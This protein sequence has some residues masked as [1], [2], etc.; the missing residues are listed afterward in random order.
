MTLTFVIAITLI[1]VLKIE[2]QKEESEFTKSSFYRPNLVLKNN[3]FFLLFFFCFG[4]MIIVNILSKTRV[5]SFRNFGVLLSRV[6]KEC[7]IK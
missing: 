7:I 2:S 6:L 3:V 4:N 1:S 5:V